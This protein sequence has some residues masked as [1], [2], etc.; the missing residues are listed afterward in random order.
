[1]ST[2]NASPS[3]GF[4]SASARIVAAI[5]GIESFCKNDVKAMLVKGDNVKDCKELNSNLA[6]S[7]AYFF[8]I[9]FFLSAR[10]NTFFFFDHVKLKGNF[11]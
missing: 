1:M 8:G 9:Y 4:T 11:P 5:V 7:D 10:R 6:I 3:T 2:S